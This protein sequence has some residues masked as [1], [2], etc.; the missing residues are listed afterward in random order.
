MSTLLRSYAA[1]LL[2]LLASASLAAACDVTIGMQGRF[3]ERETKD[4]QV[5]G[6]PDL[7]LVTFDGSI[8]VRAWDR[9]DVSVEV[10]KH[11]SSKEALGQIQVNASQSGNRITVEVRYPEQE[12]QH[13]SFSGNRSARLIVS[14]PRQTNID[15]HSGDGSVSIERVNGRV[16]LDTGDG[17]IRV[18]EVNGEVRVHT[19]DGS[20]TLARVDGRVDAETGDGTISVSGR[21]EAVRLK[22]GDG[23]VRV[24][25][26]TGSRMA[27]NW[28]ID[29]GDGSVG[30]ELP[31]S[32]DA[33][34]DAHSNDGSVAVHDLDVKGDVTMT[35]SSVRGQIGAGGP[36]IRV[37]SGSG[38]ITISRS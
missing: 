9:S 25:A 7:N 26:D 6:V 28:E 5:S 4:F 14:V 13:F 21:F 27:E 35:K 36:T 38:S 30:L 2:P 22:T 1:R 8:E 37:T 12:R 10:E 29:T 34:I 3:T 20:M 18:T 32:F 33:G 11:A 23:T 24:R 16:R 19:G 17:S 31:S 15:A